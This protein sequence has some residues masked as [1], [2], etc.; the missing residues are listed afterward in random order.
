MPGRE[1]AE[2][3]TAHDVA[4]ETEPQVGAQPQRLDINALIVAVEPVSDS[5]SIHNGG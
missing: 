1:F 2:R 3:S 5:R 4:G